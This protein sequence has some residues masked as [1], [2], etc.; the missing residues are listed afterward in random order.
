LTIYIVVGDD[1]FDHWV[2]IYASRRARGRGGRGGSGGRG[3]RGGGGDRRGGGGGGRGG[4]RRRGGRGG[5]GDRG[6]YRG[7][8]SFDGEG[9]SQVRMKYES[10]NI[11][12]YFIITN[13]ILTMNYHKDG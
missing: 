6:G 11:Y 7:K 9:G 4:D 12:I 2:N 10:C 8:R 1:E 13:F 5:G 3:G